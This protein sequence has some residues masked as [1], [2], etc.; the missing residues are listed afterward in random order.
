M[1]QLVTKSR[2]FTEP[3]RS[4]QCFIVSSDGFYPDSDEFGKKLILNFVL[5][6]IYV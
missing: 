5:F 3:E 2:C 1:C 4:L 6:S